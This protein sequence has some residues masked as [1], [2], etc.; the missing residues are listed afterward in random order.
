MGDE[1]ACA[2][3]E[4]SQRQIRRL[5]KGLEEKGTD[6]LKHGNKGKLPPNAIGND[7]KEEIVRLYL[8]KYTPANFQHFTE[9]LDELESIRISVATVKRVM[10]EAGI[11]SPQ[12]KRKPKKHKR[13]AR[14]EQHGELVQTD[15]TPHDFFGI[16]RKTCLHGAIDD[17][18]GD[19]VGLYMTENECLDGYFDVFE[20]M[21]ENFGVPVSMY[22]DRHTIFASP[23]ADK[24]TIED[25]L[26]GVMVKETQLGR[27]M[28]ELGITLIW[29]RSP[30][31]KGRIERLWRTLQDRLTNEFRIR[32]I[33][34]IEDAN[35]FFPGFVKRYNKCFSVEA[36]QTHSL[37]VPNIQDLISILC[38][39]EARTI[40]S[41]GAFSFY[42]QT[43][44]IDAFIRPGTKLEVIVHRKHG[45]FALHEGV[46][47]IVR[48]IAKPKRN[49]LLSEP[50]EQTSRPV[51]DSHYYKRGKDSYMQYSGEYN[52]AEIMTI[53]REIFDK[54]FKGS[55][56]TIRKGGAL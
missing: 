24:L 13:R 11:K 15:A 47:H 42:G 44:V 12:S 10:K 46:R 18:T 19:V 43:F 30:Q 38:V 45:I 23:V 21:I 54:N 48:R 2:L 56:M 53:I 36:A 7:I 6:A 22:A 25:E 17:A 1:Q 26:A 50:K 5:K 9:M 37:F 39:R 29:A 35:A 4:L 32:G 20:Q 51:P 16:G 28:R 49:K 33:T 14:R 40:D 52:D 41:G 34:T 55:G 3:L 8:E 31:A 27:A